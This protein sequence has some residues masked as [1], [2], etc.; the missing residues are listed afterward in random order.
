VE[1]GAG[2]EQ[3]AG[4]RAHQFA[5]L[6]DCPLHERRGQIWRSHDARPGLFEVGNRVM[7]NLATLQRLGPNLNRSNPTR[8]GDARRRDAF[9]P[10]IL[11]HGRPS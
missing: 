8:L 5:L 9:V 3:L 6:A 4:V 1:L 10:N 7:H 11:G 2:Q